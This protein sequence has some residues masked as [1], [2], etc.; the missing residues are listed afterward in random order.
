VGGTASN[1]DDYT[2]SATPLTI[3][4]GSTSGSVTVAVVADGVAEP[5]ETVVITLGASTGATLASPSVHT[6]TITGQTPTVSFTAATQTVSEGTVA[7]ITAQLSEPSTQAVAVPFTVGGTALNPD[8][9]TRSGGPITIPT[10]STTGTITVTTLADGVAEPDETVIVTLGSPTNATLASPSVHTLTIAAQPLP[11]VNLTSASQTVSEGVGTATITAQLSGPSSQVVT[12]PFTVGGTALNPADYTRSG[13]PITIPAGSTNGT[14]TVTT[15]AD[16]VA[17]PDETV[18]VT[19]GSPTNATLASPSVHTLT[20]AG[21]IPT[22]SF[23]A[24]TQTVAEGAVATITAQLS[25]PSTQAVTVPYTVGGSAS[26]PADYTIDASP[27]TIPA[28]STTGTVTVTVVADGVAEPDET[29]IVTLGSPTNATLASPSVHTLTI[30]AQVPKVSFT[31]AAQTVSEGV[32]TATITAQLSSPSTQTVTVPFTVGGTASNPDDYSISASPL[33][34]APGITTRTI[35]VDIVND[36]LAEAN[37]TVVVTLSPPTNATRLSPFVHT[38]TI[39]DDDVHPPVLSN[40]SFTLVAPVSSGCDVFGGPLGAEYQYEFSYSDPGG[41]VI[42]PGAKDSL[43]YQF[44]PSSI[45]G[46]FDRTSSTYT[47]TGFSGTISNSVCFLFDADTDVDVAM[48]V[49][50]YAGNLSAP[51]TTNVPKPSGAN[52]V[53]GSQSVGA[54]RRSPAVRAGPR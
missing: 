53:S 16:G 52:F 15:V 46:G 28:G 9:Y 30:G 11:T 4:A 20:I 32:E 23:T 7:T 13:G 39:T 40:L 54:I 10:G 1:P 22:V 34:F 19:L 25:E 12:V 36:F 47:G 37:R 24:A 45:S 43:A 29:V 27:L 8:D 3:P 33:S 49:T 18:I 48:F 17:E 44:N 38:L 41:D 51:I 35:T 5:N 42:T 14:I 26:D 2:I 21:Q 6:L 31:V 50:D